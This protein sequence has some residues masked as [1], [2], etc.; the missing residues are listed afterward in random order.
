M[1][2]KSCEHDNGSSWK[3]INIGGDWEIY[4]KAGF[5]ICR[6]CK[7][8]K[9]EKHSESEI[10]RYECDSMD[11]GHKSCYDINRLEEALTS[12][13]KLYEGQIESLEK[14]LSM[15]YSKYKAWSPNSKIVYVEKALANLAEFRSKLK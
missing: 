9:Q 12:Q 15:F 6:F 4:P 8:P 11:C 3:K 13:A 10:K 14:A 7:E 2:S 1:S 5:P